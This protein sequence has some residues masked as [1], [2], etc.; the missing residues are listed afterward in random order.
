[1]ACAQRCAIGEL[2]DRI[3]SFF[4]LYDVHSLCVLRGEED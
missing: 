2:P 4:G 3:K 1:M